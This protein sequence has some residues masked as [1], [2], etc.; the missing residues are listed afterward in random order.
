MAN[1]EQ[2]HATARI[3]QLF[4]PEDLVARFVL[5]MSMAS[6]DIERSASPSDSLG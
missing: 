5:S 6:S 3:S 1:P 2:E 4:S